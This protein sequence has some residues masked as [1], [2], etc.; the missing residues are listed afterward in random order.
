[1][2]ISELDEAVSSAIGAAWSSNTLSTRNSQ[3][4]RYLKFCGDTDLLPL[5]AELQTV[6]RFL[7]YLARD[8]KYSTINNYLSSIVSLHRF[9]GYP[10]S[11]RDSFLIKLVM[12][13]LRSQ[14]GDRVVQMQ[15]LSVSQLLEIYI[16][17]VTSD[18]DNLYWHVIVLSFRSLLRKSN[19][20]PDTAK[21]MGHVV[22]R[23][24]VKMY[25]W[26]IM[27]LVRSSKTLQCNEYVLEIPIYFVPG[28]PFCVASA[29]RDHM[30]E[31]PGYLEGP[32]FRRPMDRHST[33]VLY[34][35]VLQFL[36]R[37][38]TA[39]GLPPHEYGIHSLRR[40]G[41]SFLHGMGV[42]LQDLM[43]M[44]DWHSLAVLDY[45]VT[46]VNKKKDIQSKV[47]DALRVGNF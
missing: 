19:I 34:K 45:L 15:P 13:G 37:A 17:C 42:P 31:V 21:D 27:L 7:V 8:C 22:R 23:C 30:E 32:I 36:K 9:Y 20:V 26:G 28:S 3:W 1:M 41:V 24:D 14:L 10:V 2:S 38:V 40:S 29:V 18:L 6:A 44:G 5:P 39:I 33:P 46:T 16:K 43:S 11:F 35:D 47:C 25:S 12:K 4:R